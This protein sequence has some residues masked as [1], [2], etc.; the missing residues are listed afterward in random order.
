LD[1]AEIEQIKG[2][3]DP[4]MVDGVTTN[5]VTQRT[6]IRSAVIKAPAAMTGQAIVGL[7]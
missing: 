5:H 2:P 7:A 6:L 1:T 4:R 3:N